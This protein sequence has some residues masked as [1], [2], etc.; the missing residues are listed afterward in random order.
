MPA[1]GMTQDTGEILSWNFELGARVKADDILFE[2]ETDKTTV[3][4]EAGSA[5]IIVEVRASAGEAVP[6]GAVIA[7]IDTDESATPTVST[8]AVSSIVSDTTDASV[9]STLEKPEVSKVISPTKAPSIICRVPTRTENNSSGVQASGH[10]LASPK[11]KLAARDKGISLEQLVAAGIEQPLQYVD[12]QNYVPSDSTSGHSLSLLQ[13]RV[14]HTA[15][16]DFLEWADKQTDTS[17]ISGSVWSLFASSAWRYSCASD[18]L[19]DVYVE[20]EHWSN[21][22][23]DLFSI[24]ADRVGLL[25]IVS[26]EPNGYVDVLVRDMTGTPLTHYQSPNEPDCPSLTVVD[27]GADHLNLSLRFN[28][29][30]LSLDSAMSLLNRVCQLVEQPLRHLL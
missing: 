6:V 18:P 27:D 30:S 10:I 1:L 11:A 28:E 22:E 13:A 2:V 20:L 17:N 16:K 7:V 9:S 26:Y 25:E 19:A 3:E 8:V 21:R 15:Y 29:T 24:N 12:V 23:A 14:E 4:I 5:G